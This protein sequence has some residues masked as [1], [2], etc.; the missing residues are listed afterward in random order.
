MTDAKPS[1]R[2]AIE[3]TSGSGAHT[4][5]TYRI[6]TPSGAVLATDL[7]D[8][9]ADDLIEVKSSI[10]R[11]TLRLALGQILDY[12]RFIR[13]KLRTLL[14]PERPAQEMIDLFS[15][16]AMGSLGRSTMDS[17]CLD[18]DR[19]ALSRIPHRSSATNAHVWRSRRRV[20]STWHR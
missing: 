13:P 8:V 6:P 12:E 7:Y 3:I 19:F 1:C 5:M 17:R 2:S 18:V 9:T 16:L 10:D 4:V 14:V 15:T 11:E 20:P